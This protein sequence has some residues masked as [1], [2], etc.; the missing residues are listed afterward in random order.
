MIPKEIEKENSSR[1]RFTNY[2]HMF[3]SHSVTLHHNLDA[4]IEIRCSLS[5]GAG[6]FG[7][8]FLLF[9]FCWLSF[10]KPTKNWLRLPIAVKIILTPWIE[11]R[12]K[13]ERKKPNSFYRPLETVF[14]MLVKCAMQIAK[15]SRKINE[16]NCRTNRERKAWPKINR[17]KNLTKETINCKT[18]DDQKNEMAFLS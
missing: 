13:V 4:T 3:R 7:R 14:V 11:I 16:R 1:W 10:C 17:D 2:I 18:M 8:C 6:I 15:P 9:V 5:L 12:V